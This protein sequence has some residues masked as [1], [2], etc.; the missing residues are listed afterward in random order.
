M[1]SMLFFLFLGIYNFSTGQT[2]SFAEY[3]PLKNE[4]ANLFYVSHITGTDTIKG[5]NTYLCC[6]SLSIN[7]RQIFYFE[8]DGDEGDTSII[9][10][11]SFCHG[12]FYFDKGAFL[13]SPIFWKYELKQANLE[14]F[15]P[16]FPATIS[17]DTVYKFQNGEERRNYKFTGFEDVV[18]KDSVFKDCLKLTITRNWI[19]AQY[20]D[21][22]WFQKGFGM[23]KRLKSTGRLEEVNLV[24]NIGANRRKVSRNVVLNRTA[25]FTSAPQFF[26]QIRSKGDKFDTFLK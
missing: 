9:G 24:E 17:V 3:F 15:E 1:K 11:N 10:S 23:V 4:N 8:N 18:I 12:V 5:N 19:T 2:I 7:K 25:T 20:I 16:L 14:Y 6:S 26:K 13:F 21:T 22:V